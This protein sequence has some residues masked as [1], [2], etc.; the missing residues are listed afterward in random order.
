MCQTEIFYLFKA[1][2]VVCIAPFCL[3]F[4]CNLFRRHSESIRFSCSINVCQNHM[5]C[6][7]KCLDE[8]RE[9]SFRTCISMRL[10][11]APDL[12]MRIMGRSSQCC[13]N[14]CRMMCI[15]INDRYTISLA[16]VFKTTVCTVKFFQSLF[17][18]GNIYIQKIC[19]SKC[20][21][22][23]GYIMVSTYR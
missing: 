20:G 6:M 12:T 18:N 2:E 10:E 19:N 16:F 4:I 11:N 17:G 14:L 13:S 1:W 21:K 5:I 15:V 22:C 7:R 9:E 3:Q 8:F 23:V